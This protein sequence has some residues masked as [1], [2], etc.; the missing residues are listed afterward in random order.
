MILHLRTLA[1]ELAF[2]WPVG[3]FER[4]VRAVVDVRFSHTGRGG[5]FCLDRI[6]GI[7]TSTGFSR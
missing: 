6:P 3:M 5:G 7:E 1:Q 2:E 4:L